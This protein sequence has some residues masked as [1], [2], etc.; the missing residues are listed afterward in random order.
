MKLLLIVAITIVL[1]GCGAITKAGIIRKD[2]TV[3]N[4]RDF[5][6]EESTILYP[7]SIRYIETHTSA[8]LDSTTSSTL[9]VTIEPHSVEA[10]SVWKD[11]IIGIFG[12]IG[13]KVI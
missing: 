12:F 5:H 8:T 10:R 3:A 7:P 6:Y 1:T 9:D 2:P 13:G 11:L 4:I